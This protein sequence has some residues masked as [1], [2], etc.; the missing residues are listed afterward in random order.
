MLK[1]DNRN[2]NCFPGPTNV[3]WCNGKV[4]LK[5]DKA[6]RVQTV[7]TYFQLRVIQIGNLE[8]AKKFIDE[9]PNTIAFEAG[10][11]TNGQSVPRCLCTKVDSKSVTK[12][13]S[14]C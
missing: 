14:P 6:N 1:I 11:K 3:D 9:V 12:A 5:S 10:E 7:H 2:N 4:L 8:L 13:H